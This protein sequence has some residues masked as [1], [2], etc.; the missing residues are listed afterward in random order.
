MEDILGYEIWVNIFST[1]IFYEELKNLTALFALRA[2]KLLFAISS[3]K[4]LVDL[5]KVTFNIRV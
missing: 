1:T 3:R 4:F 5:N 2:E